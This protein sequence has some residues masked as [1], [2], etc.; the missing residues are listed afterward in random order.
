MGP[1]LRCA[2][3]RVPGPQAKRVRVLVLGAGEFARSRC[4][5]N[6]GIAQRSAAGHSRVFR[7]HC[8]EGISRVTT[9]LALLTVETPVQQF[10]RLKGPGMQAASLGR[11]EQVVRGITQQYV[12]K[13]VR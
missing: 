13:Q 7:H 10:K 5:S 9:V 12:A 11:R 3:R 2:N 4:L 1:L 8:S 6:L